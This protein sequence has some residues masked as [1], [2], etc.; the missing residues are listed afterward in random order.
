[1]LKHYIKVFLIGYPIHLIV[2]YL[3]NREWEWIKTLVVVAI[4]SIFLGLIN[5]NQSKAKKK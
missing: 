2:G 4:L 5:Y 3:L 1:M